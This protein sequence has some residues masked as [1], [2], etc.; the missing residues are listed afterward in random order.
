MNRSGRTPTEELK[1]QLV[2]QPLHGLWGAASGLAPWVG[3]LVA[4]RSQLAWNDHLVGFTVGSAL[5]LGSVAGWVVREVAQAKDGS[6]TW[7]DPWLDS[8]IFGLA[9]LLSLFISLT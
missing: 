8:G 1:K 5:L 4:E 2:D 6:H 3:A 9:L 7:W